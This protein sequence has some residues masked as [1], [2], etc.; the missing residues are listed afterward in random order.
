MKHRRIKAYSV[1]NIHIIRTLTMF[2]AVLFTVLSVLSML[3]AAA[4]ASATTE[5]TS[6]GISLL[7]AEI[8]VNTDTLEVST[9]LLLSNNGSEDK[10]VTFFLPVI[11][12]GMDQDTLDLKTSE[13]S[14]GSLK[15]RKL[16]LHIGAGKNAGVFY[17]YKMSA[18]A[19]YNDL[20][21]FDLRQFSDCFDER[22]GH[23]RWTVDLPAWEFLQVNEIY[24]A[25]Y[26]LS[27]NRV[28]V[29]LNNFSICPEL[30][31]VYLSRP[32]RMDLLN[33]ISQ[34]EENGVDSTMDRFILNHYKSWYEDP[35]Y[36]KERLIF[37]EL[38]YRNRDSQD[39]LK[40]TLRL[41]LLYL[42]LE[43][44]GTAGEWETLFAEVRQYTESLYAGGE[45]FRGDKYDIET[46]RE[47]YE[48]G[49]AHSGQAA[50]LFQLLL[51]D[52]DTGLA[53]Y[54]GISMPYYAM[55]HPEDQKIY[56]VILPDLTKFGGKRA[57]LN[58]D[59]GLVYMTSSL[60]FPQAE[61]LLLEQLHFQTDSFRLFLLHEADLTDPEA[62]SDLLNAL[63]TDLVVR[64][65]FAPQ[66]PDPENTV[67]RHFAYDA[68]ET[69]PF[70][71][72][73]ADLA[74][75]R[76]DAFGLDTCEEPLKNALDVPV[77]TQYCG[78]VIS[79]ETDELSEENAVKYELYKVAHPFTVGSKIGVL[80]DC[81]TPKKML[82]A[83]DEAARK[84][85]GKNDLL[86]SELRSEFGFPDLEASQ[87]EEP[88]TQEPESQDPGSK[89]SETEDPGTVES[90]TEDRNG[91]SGAEGDSA[92]P[93]PHAPDNMNE[94][95]PKGLTLQTI[96]VFGGGLLMLV[97]VIVVAV[98]LFRKL[99][100]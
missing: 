69:W 43:E 39:Y 38:E 50:H 97:V 28:S 37:P 13:G 20:L 26:Q 24:P 71:E 4:L 81:A 82:E 98:M 96:L 53:I 40:E 55:K 89:E 59:D 35:D 10:E 61:A 100:K 5:S 86:I 64:L 12:S 76:T 54:D 92:T 91:T 16:T 95:P 75:V 68:T 99:K 6:I 9:E 41:T 65:A 8:L 83:R 25:N 63:N 31:R 11:S 66:D 72:F 33:E 79:V 80:T 94:D 22:I 23:F 62:T 51:L 30:S 3:P 7:S 15:G 56:A 93:T 44:N 45:P 32:T 87:S 17:T 58:Y 14:E 49:S 85:T 2:L 88:G 67:Q 46:L 42:Y 70:D 19:S 47:Y 78:H 52:M 1:K 84:A 77:F 36:V 34:N 48:L 18:S 57:V 74:T 29:E 90:E 60:P 73:R 21:A 27:Q